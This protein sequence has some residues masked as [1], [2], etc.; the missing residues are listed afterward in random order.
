M[1]IFKII[2]IYLNILG[3]KIINTIIIKSLGR[4]VYKILI[5]L[6]CK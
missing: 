1:L 4:I 3:I 2:F 5:L 6:Y